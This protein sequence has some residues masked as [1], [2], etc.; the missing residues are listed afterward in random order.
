MYNFEAW[1]HLYH[2]IS[3]LGYAAPEK[4]YEVNVGLLKVRSSTFCKL[5]M[6]L[7]LLLPLA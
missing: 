1:S 5:S 6:E 7:Y 4:H 2:T 3:V